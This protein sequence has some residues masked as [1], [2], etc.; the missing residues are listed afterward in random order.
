MERFNRPVLG[1]PYC[2]QCGYQLTGLTESTR[3]PE[4]GRPIV[5]V[6]TRGKSKAVWGKRYVSPTRIFGL[7]LVHIATGPDEHNKRGHAKG[8]VAVGDIAT[9]FFAFGGVARGLVAFGGLAVGL[10]SFGGLGIGLAIAM[11]GWAVGGL[12]VGGGSLGVV[13]QGGGAIGYVADGG[14]AYG[15][16]ARGG[17][18]GG[19][20]VIPIGG[21]ATPQAT[22]KI[23]PWLF[24]IGNT[25]GKMTLLFW[26][27]IGA[28]AT[29]AV[30]GLVILMGY[31]TARS[32]V[33]EPHSGYPP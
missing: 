2:A 16:I 17:G 3:C 19:T 20:Y 23:Q 31:L 7:P 15:Y 5:E 22:Q 14:G 4:C 8:I 28:V 11:G 21:M 32:E 26:A 6:L 33:A 12:A 13:A 10:V 30:V 27:L 1:D 25:P 24:L 18:A 9:G 29:S